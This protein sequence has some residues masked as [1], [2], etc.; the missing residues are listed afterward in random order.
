MVRQLSGELPPL[1]GIQIERNTLLIAAQAAPPERRTLIE[2]APY[3][4]GVALLWR[5]DLDDFSAKVGQNAASKRPGKELTEFKDTHPL[6]RACRNGRG[7]CHSSLGAMSHPWYCVP[8]L[9]RQFGAGRDVVFP[10]D[11]AQ[12]TADILSAALYE[13]A[14]LHV[15]CRRLTPGPR[16]CNCAHVR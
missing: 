8:Q 3:P 2:D 11:A 16:R 15:L 14:G 9:P 10:G 1:V 13:S 5:L 6:K 12:R 7:G 4:Q